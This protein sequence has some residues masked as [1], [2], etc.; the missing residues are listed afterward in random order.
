MC[1]LE[2][3]EN[4]N[5]CGGFQNFMKE[6]VFNALLERAKSQRKVN[7][8][9]DVIESTLQSILNFID[10][11]NSL[12]ENT[13]K[14]L[15]MTIS[16]I[17]VLEEFSMLLTPEALRIVANDVLY[18][19]LLVRKVADLKDEGIVTYNHYISC[20]A[21]WRNFFKRGSATELVKLGDFK[22]KVD[23]NNYIERIAFDD[24]CVASNTAYWPIQVD[25]NLK[26][27]VATKLRAM[28]PTDEMCLEYISKVNYQC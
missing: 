18:P 23:L 24:W 28:V 14:C 27:F 25:P 20:L 10:L 5:H 4:S 19:D 15:G 3:G 1:K 13:I 6:I 22:K 11:F 16:E 12:P 21:Q 9:D 2:K 26:P 17:P 8:K 7:V